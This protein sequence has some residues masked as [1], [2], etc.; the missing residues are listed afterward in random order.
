MASKKG[1]KKKS[2]NGA[3]A[4]AEAKWTTGENPRP[5][6]E[7]APLTRENHGNPY[8]R[9]L[10]TEATASELAL[11]AHELAD[12]LDEEKRVKEEKR[13]ANAVYRQKLAG[14]DDR[15]AKL[16]ECVKTDRKLEQVKVQEVLRSDNLI[17]VIRTDTGVVIETRTATADDLQ[18]TIRIDDE[19]VAHRK[20]IEDDED[21]E[22]E[23]PECGGEND[24]HQ[25]NCSHVSAKTD[26]PKH[27]VC[28]HCGI[29]SNGGEGH[30][31][32]CPRAEG[33][34]STAVT[35][36]SDILAAAAEVE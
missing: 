11:I 17:E 28:E 6:E 18:R 30:R 3:E 10:P 8:T 32:D 4:T 29:V 7:Q 13:E 33:D 14:L 19:K 25:D 22:D 31:G 9:E 16:S 23:C 26:P 20:L 2:K 35:D 12:V 21:D 34:P 24:V 15:K 36:P 27:E 1:R 5:I